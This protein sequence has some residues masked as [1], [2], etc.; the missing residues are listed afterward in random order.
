[1]KRREEQGKGVGGK[2]GGE[3]AKV[4]GREGPSSTV[5]RGGGSDDYY[6]RLK[7]ERGIPTPLRA[8]HLGADSAVWAVSARRGRVWTNDI[9]NKYVN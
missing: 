3:G 4:G 2:K 7:P 6:S 8:C 1:M 5:G 9:T